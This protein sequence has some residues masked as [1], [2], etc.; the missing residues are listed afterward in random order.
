[1]DT[2]HLAVCGVDVHVHGHF[3]AIASHPADVS[4]LYI[5]VV[6]ALFVASYSKT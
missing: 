4:T 1:M 2:M 6:S 3:I 5:L